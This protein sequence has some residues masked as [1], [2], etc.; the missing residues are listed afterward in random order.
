[1]FRAEADTDAE[2]G[3]SSWADQGARFTREGRKDEAF[4]RT[5]G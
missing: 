2:A 3:T 4:H 5:Q 1:V